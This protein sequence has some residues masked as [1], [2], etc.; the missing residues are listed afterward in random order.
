MS[1]KGG[2]TPLDDGNLSKSQ[3]PLLMFAVLTSAP[4]HHCLLISW[5]GLLVQMQHS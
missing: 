4:K 5:F 2:P 1:K 3:H